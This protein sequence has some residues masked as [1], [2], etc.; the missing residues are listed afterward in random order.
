[1]DT[2]SHLTTISFL[3]GAEVGK[4]CKSRAVVLDALPFTYL[5]GIPLPTGQTRYRMQTSQTNT[6]LLVTLEYQC[7]DIYENSKYY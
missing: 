3:Y 4:K 2:V 6:Q 7:T 1:M 5:Y